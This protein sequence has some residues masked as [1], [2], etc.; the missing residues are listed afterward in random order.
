[1][2][3]SYSGICQPSFYYLPLKEHFTDIFPLIISLRKM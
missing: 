1:M 3:L 2:A